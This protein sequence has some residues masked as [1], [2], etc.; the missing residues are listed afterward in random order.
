MQYLPRRRGPG[1]GSGSD[2][3]SGSKAL[4]SSQVSVL[5][6]VHRGWWVG[7]RTALVSARVAG[8]VGGWLGGWWLAGW[9]VSCA[10]GWWVVAGGWWV[11]AGGW[12]LMAGGWWLVA[13][14]WWLVAGGWWVAGWRAGRHPFL[15]VE[16][17]YGGNDAQRC[18]YEIVDAD[19][20][21]LE[22]LGLGRECGRLALLTHGMRPPGAQRSPLLG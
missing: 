17:G 3:K 20:Q 4:R 13:G 12:W 11:L 7:P 5:A 6:K 21:V 1:L 10:G 15:D 9:L 18:L 14:G 16:P 19:T 8:W 22:L 2:L